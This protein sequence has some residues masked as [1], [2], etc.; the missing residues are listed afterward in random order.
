MHP[1]RHAY[2]KSYNYS[3]R[4]NSSTRM[5]TLKA[6]DVDSDASKKELVCKNCNYDNW[7]LK[8]LH[9]LK[10]YKDPWKR[11]RLLCRDHEPIPWL[12]LTI[13]HIFLVFI[14]SE[15]AGLT[16]C[17]E[18][19]A[20]ASLNNFP[21]SKLPL[22]LFR[23]IVTLPTSCWAIVACM[24]WNCSRLQSFTQKKEKN[25]LNLLKWTLIHKLLISAYNL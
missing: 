22:P 10:W 6:S 19:Q 17:W 11:G 8:F 2:T 1:R 16:F 18:I 14:V 4:T 3:A 21:P 20:I 24:C 9:V 7:F 25:A 12:S 5:M 15:H 13:Q 23:L